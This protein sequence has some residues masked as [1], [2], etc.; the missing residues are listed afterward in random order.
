MVRVV[1]SRPHNRALKALSGQENMDYDAVDIYVEDKEDSMKKGERDYYTEDE[2]HTHGDSE[3]Y[4]TDKASPV[5][6]KSEEPLINRR[7]PGRKPQ[8]QV[9]KHT[10]LT[11]TR[12]RARL[13]DNLRTVV[14]HAQSLADHSLGNI[15]S[16][17]NALLWARKLLLRPL[18]FH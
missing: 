6:G 10:T 16:S 11:P 1:V 2:D 4:D 18:S 12:G 15:E 9:V 17:S 3:G 5:K 7:I 14:G 13:S 8:D